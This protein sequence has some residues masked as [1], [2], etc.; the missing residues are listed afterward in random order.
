MR[1]WLK[2]T[3]RRLFARKWL[4]PFHLWLHRVALAGMGILN[5]EDFA[6][7]GEDHFLANEL[8]RRVRPVEVVVDV[9]AHEGAYS[10][11]AR[12]LWPTARILSFEPNPR[13]FERLVRRAELDGF[14]AI[15]QGCSN[16]EGMVE[17]F[18]LAGQEGSSHA[19]VYREVVEHSHGSGI[20][21]VAASVTS[22]DAFA[23]REGLE[24]IDLLKIDAEG[25]ELHVLLGAKRLIAEGRINAI[26]FEFNEMNAFSG[27]HF[28]DFF[29][30]LR[31]FELYRLLPAG[32]VELAAYRPVELEIFAFQNIVAF[33][34]VAA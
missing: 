5:Y 18:D 2:A 8:E 17:L 29:E 30:L 9:G 22:L 1:R 3:Y 15:N 25:H 11:R 34:R 12:S 32:M 33:R 31:D 14:V 4:Y 27:V 10:S 21:A 7:S 23:S 16:R 28:R 13:T 20:T 19:S 26:H 24:R 6:A